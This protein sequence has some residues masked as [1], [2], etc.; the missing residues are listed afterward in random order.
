MYVEIVL[1]Q[2]VVGREFAKVDFVKAEKRLNR[3]VDIYVQWD[4]HDL[5]GVVDFV[6]TENEGDDSEHR[7]NH[8]AGILGVKDLLDVASLALVFYCQCL[9]N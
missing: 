8:I 5:V 9:R 7:N 3:L 2:D 1:A 6:E 4:L